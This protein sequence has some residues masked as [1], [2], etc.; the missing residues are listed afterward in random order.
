MQKATS[1]LLGTPDLPAT[2]KFADLLR[3]LVDDTTSPVSC[4][5]CRDSGWAPAGAGVRRCDC[6]LSRRPVV[7]E[8]VPQGLYRATI[9]NYREIPG[10]E[11]A[12]TAAR[13]FLRGTRDLYLAG[14]VGSGKTR[15]ACSILNDAYREGVPGLFV[16]VPAL[17]LDLQPGR[18]DDV[19]A[20][21]HLLFDRLCRVPLAVLDDVGAE[22]DIAS[23]YTRRTLLEIYERRGENALRTI[24]TSNL[25]LAPKAEQ[26]ALYPPHR[27]PTLAEFMGDARLASRIVERA[28]AIW[29]GTPDQRLA[30]RTREDRREEA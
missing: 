20:A 22:R 18:P 16:R 26:A 12:L 19:Q 5:T 30:L 9:D 28:Q 13:K 1:H 7:A 10:N 3:P 8:G 6:W 17:L 23:D 2:R 15:L 14:N 24:W 21:A 4:A 29:L 11:A 27:P 25:R